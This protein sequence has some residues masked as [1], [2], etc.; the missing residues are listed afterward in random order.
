MTNPKTVASLFENEPMRW[1]L[2]GDPHLWREMREHFEKTTLPDSADELI[3]FVET[4]FEALTNHPI[5]ER[6]FF[7]IERF[8]DGGMS[9]GMISSEFWRDKVLPMMRVRYFDMKKT[10]DE[11]S[12]HPKSIA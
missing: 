2:R 3:A 8:S 1:G 10:S 7:F 6:D 12:D 11:S 9:R 4:M 5:S